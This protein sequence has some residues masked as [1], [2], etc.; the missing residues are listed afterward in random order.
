MQDVQ[1]IDDAFFTVVHQENDFEIGKG[2]A[3]QPAVRNACVCVPNPDNVRGQYRIMTTPDTPKDDPLSWLERHIR[4]CPEAPFLETAVGGVIRYGELDGITRRVAAALRALGVARGERVCV[5]LE[6]SVETVFLYIAALRMGAVYMPLNTA[7]TAAE[8]EYFLEDARPRVLLADPTLATAALAAAASRTGTRLLTLDSQGEGSFADALQSAAPDGLPD[9]LGGEDLAALIYTS[10]TTGRSK[11][12][13]LTR[14]N[15][16]AGAQALVQAWGVRPE[17]VLLHVLPLFHVHGLFIALT[18]VMAARASL[19]FLPRF[20]ARET[21]ACL[22]RATLFMGVPTHYTRLLALPGLDRN[23]VAT[24]RL[25]ISGSAPLLPETH[26]EFESRCGQV[27]LERYGMTETVVNA[28]NPLHGVRK[29]GSVGPP[30][31]GVS[32]RLAPLVDAGDASV[33]MIEVRGPSVF[34]GYWKAEQKTRESFREDGYFITGDVGRFDEDGYL[35]IVGRARDLIISGGYNVYP[36]EVE[37]ALDR[38]AGV[39]ESAV[40][41]L[42]HPDFGEGVTA[43]VVAR[44]GAAPSEA[45]LIA[46]L[47]QRLAAYKLPKRILFAD[48]LP[49]NAMGKV[50]KA[51]LR[52]AHAALYGR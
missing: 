25:F 18:T 8:L 14:G 3:R 52:T 22:P 2:A 31:P 36:V 19:L 26:R 11:G 27:I 49:R 43:V 5:A 6:K 50:Q 20:D 48:E 9:A 32:L 28:S 15:L 7:Y 51:A 10:G 41:G 13:M 42:P 38:L 34:R 12:A 30:L 46:Q 16:A 17:D 37:E 33:G 47:R 21:L 24:I 1:Q 4:D 35:Y 44:P 40:I 29:P 23:A 39:A 45:E